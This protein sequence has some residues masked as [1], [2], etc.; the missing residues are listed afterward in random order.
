MLDSWTRRPECA[1]AVSLSPEVAASG[2]V[3]ALPGRATGEASL[4]VLYFHQHFTT[5]RGAGGTRSYEFARRL[6]Q[7]GHDVTIV[8]GSGGATGL[9]GPFE[10]GRRSGRVEEFRVVEF[11]LP[12]AN[13]QS[14]R[15]RAATFL[16][17]AW[18]SLGVVWRHDCDVVFCTSTP[19]TAA[20][21]GIFAKVVRR[22]T[23]VFEVRDLWPELPRAM[24]V[25][26]NPLILGAMSFLEW[27]AY[28]YADGLIGLAPGISEGLARFGA[29]ASRIRT[30]PN[31]CDLAD[32]GGSGP[33]WRPAQ[34]SDQAFLA[35]FSGAMGI[36][37]NAEAALAA[38]AVLKRRGRRDIWLLLIGDGARWDAIAARVEAEQ[39]DRVVVHPAIPK[40]RMRELLRGCDVGLQMLANVP[41]F[42]RGTSPN[43]FFDYLASGLPVLVNYP[44]WLAEL[45]ERERCGIAVAPENPEAFADA[46]ETLADDREK[47][48]AMGSRGRR[49]GEMEF[50]REDLASSFCEFVE[51]TWRRDREYRRARA[52]RSLVK[53]IFDIAGATVALIVLSPLML[54]TAALVRQKLGAPVLFRQQRPGRGGKVFSLL[55]FRTMTDVRSD[56][57]SL[58]PDAERLPALGRTLRALSLDELPELWNVLK[59]DMSLVGPRPLLVE[60]LPLYSEE[61]AARHLVRPGIT[62]WAQVNGRNSLSWEE[63]FELDTWYVDNWSIWRDVAILA[64]TVWTVLCRRGISA[65]GNA[66][67]PAFK[68]TPRVPPGRT[69]KSGH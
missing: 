7:A 28:R 12:Y 60:Y 4:K 63:K 21:P 16:R 37:N 14:F 47:A 44:G 23:F 24:G 10:A 9:A 58:R 17:F 13:R 41:A 35:V 36:A 66:T 26:R 8:C 42:Y 20:L 39:L 68:G 46:L 69:P 59:G 6:A 34:I 32:F 45:I 11:E 31:G 57:G 5:P 61:Q 64:R 25:I 33:R 54:V 15:R 27:T 53:R 43:K 1:T 62:G 65:E 56:D 29:P 55:K 22:T 3:I 19:L 48:A 18:R 67:M 49:L 38:A 51:V 40:T 52:A 50:D 2:N 30:I